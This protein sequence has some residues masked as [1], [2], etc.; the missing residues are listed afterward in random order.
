MSAARP[1]DARDADAT[2]RP[3]RAAPTLDGEVAGFTLRLEGRTIPARPGDSIAAALLAADVR[4]FGRSFKH[5]RPRGYH[6]GRGHCGCC[7]MR[8]DGLPGVRTCVTPARPGMHVVREHAWPSAERDLLRVLGL[9][10]PLTPAGFY[11]RRFTRSAW[12]FGRWERLL[13]H[14]AGHGRP[15]TPAAAGALLAAPPAR[16]VTPDVLVVGG[17]AAGMSAAVTAAAGGAKTIL[18]EAHDRLG[19]DG[20]ADP[21]DSPLSRLRAEAATQPGLHVLTRHTAVGLW[22]DGPVFVEHEGGALL[23]RC[24]RIV[25]ATGCVDDRLLF[26]GCDMPG[27]VLGHGVVRLIDRHRVPPG[28]TAVVVTDRPFGY[29]V[30]ERLRDAGV[31]VRAIAD[32]R[33]HPDG[34]E[35][36]AGRTHADGPGGRRRI[37]DPTVGTRAPVLAGYTVAEARGRCEVRDVR[38]LPLA[39]GRARARRDAVR[40]ACDT[41][42][43][44]LGEHPDDS[45]FATSWARSPK[46][47]AIVPRDG[48]ATCLGVVADG[49]RA[50]V[51]G[52]AAGARTFAEAAAG[53]REAGLAAAC[54]DP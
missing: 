11:Y 24:P 50:W 41:L 20:A 38:L 40:I 52:G 17:G 30:A 10:S 28:R 37:A 31:E 45:L 4:V 32:H 36:S 19:G 1:P 15:P 34:R 3:G 43:V 7:A 46:H 27:V 25:F 21:P 12:L 14:L 22:Q 42:C 33:V 54:A 49:V 8:V 5:H 13:A 2:C 44:A 47:P 26:P 35:A 51:A 9:L 23:V 18:L 29:V 6:C 16:T 39:V 48:A 53:G